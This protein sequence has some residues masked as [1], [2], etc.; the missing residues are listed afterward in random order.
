MEGPRRTSVIIT[1][2]S[3]GMGSAATEEM[4]RRGWRVIMACRNLEKAD[5]VRRRI[6]GAVPSA[7]LEIQ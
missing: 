5:A 2:A 6:L 3:G 1:G 4:A 7:Q